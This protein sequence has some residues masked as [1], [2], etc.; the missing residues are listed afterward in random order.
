MELASGCT[1]GAHGECLCPFKKKK[2]KNSIPANILSSCMLICAHTAIHQLAALWF[3]LVEDML[4]GYKAT[5]E[6]VACGDVAGWARGV[7]HRPRKWHVLGES[8][9]PRLFLCCRFT[10]DFTHLYLTFTP[11]LL[12]L[13]FSCSCLNA[14]KSISKLL[15]SG[16]IVHDW[17][18]RL[19]WQ[20]VWQW[21][22]A[23]V[24]VN[25]LTWCGFSC[26]QLHAVWLI[27]ASS[28]L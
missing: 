28:A 5:E 17:I 20:S 8:C 6:P 23:C 26:S 14:Q 15:Q 16:Q 10:T 25:V 9:E 2:K 18:M 22:G 27:L 13:W 7:T 1:S 11:Q 19:G 3:S 24:C 12:D 4:T 21:A